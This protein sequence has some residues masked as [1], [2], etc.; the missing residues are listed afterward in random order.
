MSNVGRGFVIGA[1]VVVVNDF[2][3]RRVIN[4]KNCIGIVFS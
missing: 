4:A 1:G 3:N 2:A